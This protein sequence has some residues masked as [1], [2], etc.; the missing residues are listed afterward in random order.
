MPIRIVTDSTASLPP[1]IAADLDITVVPLHVQFG[2]ETYRDGVDIT[3]EEFYRRLQTS[4]VHPQ[5]SQANPAEFAQIYAGIPGDD[6]IVSVH[7]STDLSKTVE[8]ARQG[9]KQIEGR[10]IAVLDSRLAAAALTFTVVAAARA[11]RAGAS[12]DDIR[13]LVDDRAQRTHLLAVVT[14]LEYL[15][16]GGR[17]GGAAAFVGSLLNFKPVIELRDGIVQPVTR[18]RTLNKAYAAIRSGVAERAPNGVE[19]WAILHALAPD[20]RDRMHREVA[21]GLDAD[22][23]K[24]DDLAVVP[25]IG[26]HTGPGT[27]GFAFV[28]RP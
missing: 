6:P 26:A 3:T 9:A 21:A 2:A 25:V 27:F 20:A 22:G 24:F 11:A 23:D 16:R 19:S 12:V 18:V 10:E 5:T 8:S 13:A 7:V 15:K 28:A 17:I 4:P 14:T 1:D